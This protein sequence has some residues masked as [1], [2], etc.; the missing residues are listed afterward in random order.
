MKLRREG[1]CTQRSAG[2]HFQRSTG[3]HLYC[4]TGVFSRVGEAQAPESSMGEHRM[5]YQALEI[6]GLA[7]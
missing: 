3:L 2:L 5:Y 7:T 6:S 4:S 1:F